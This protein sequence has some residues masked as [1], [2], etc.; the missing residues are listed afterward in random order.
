MMDSRMEALLLREG[1]IVQVPVGRSMW[2][3]LK[4][5]RDML[6]IEKI[7]FPIKVH[8]V[9]LYKRDSGKYVL[10]RVVK[11]KPDGYVIRGDNCTRNEYDITERHMLGVLRG[12]Y[13]G[14]RYIDCE[15]H[16][17]YKAYV[18]FWRA[19]YLPRTAVKGV[20]HCFRRLAAIIGK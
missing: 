3:M 8:D 20:Y 7:T 17:G 1:R 16:M 2:P 19:T 4:N 11:I 15:K 10:H 13:K 6:V 9:V 18:L 12:F 5:R 14:E